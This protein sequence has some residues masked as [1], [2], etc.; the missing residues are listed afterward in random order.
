MKIALITDQHFGIRNDSTQFHE[1][2]KKFYS[3]VFF[4]TLEEHGIKDIIELGDIFDRRKYVNFDSLE[5][6]TDYFF[7]P[8]FRKG[9]NLHCIVGNH[10]TYFKNTNAVNAPRLLLGWMAGKCK[11]CITGNPSELFIYQDA[12]SDIDFDGCKIMFMPWINSGNYDRAMD[13]I[14]NSNADVVMGH[15]ELRGFEMYKGATIDAGLSHTLFEKFD[16]VMSGHFHHKSSKDNVH[17]LGSPYQMTWSDYNDDRG[18]HIFDTET[19]EL[20]YIKNPFIMFHKVFFDDVEV[21]DIPD[22]SHLKDTYVKVVVKNKNNPYVFDLFMDKLNSCEPVHVQV[23]EDNLNLDI[24]DESDFIDEA[25][26]TMTIVK[27]Y[28]EGLS[29]SLSL[30]DTQSKNVSSMLNDLYQEVLSND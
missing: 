30:S 5:R 21:D 18:F 25:E 2:Y 24:G 29:R 20:T 11:S 3:E 12:S 27:K 22:F 7:G 14:K 16:M 19:R 23:V 9:I 4:P 15:L 10:D 8:I 6:C 17:Y 13:T 26:D 1:Y 28:V